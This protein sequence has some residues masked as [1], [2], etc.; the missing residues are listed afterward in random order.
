[1]SERAH[2]TGR[3]SSFAPLVGAAPRVLILGTMPGVASLEQQQYYAQPRNAFWRIMGEL[4]AAGPELDYTLRKRRLTEAGVAVWD[5]L[6]TCV[7][8]GSL[9][10]AIVTGSEVPNDIAGLLLRFPLIRHVFFNGRKAEQL[11]QRRI[12]LQLAAEADHYAYTSLPSTSPAMAALDFAAKL[13]QWQVIRD[14][15]R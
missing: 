12:A 1:M 15:L 11:F 4:F 14:V 5:V 7:R 13:Q 6:A 8:P 3:I 2:E 10:S 9:D